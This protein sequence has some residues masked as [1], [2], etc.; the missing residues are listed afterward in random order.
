MNILLLTSK[1]PTPNPVI[2]FTPVVHYFAKEWAKQGHNVKVIHN[3]SI[4]PFF[5]YKIP[6]FL[7]KIFENK[8]GFTFPKAEM[9]NELCYYIDGVHVHKLLLFRIFPFV[10]YFN[11][12]LK[13]QTRK[14]LYINKQEGFHPDLILGHFT[15]P[16][17]PIGVALKK[18]YNCTFSMVLHTIDNDLNNYK[19]SID[20]VDVFGF[21]SEVIR[22]TFFEKG[23]KAKKKFICHSGID[24][25]EINHN[26]KN[27]NDNLKKFLFVGILIKR[28]FADVII[29]SLGS[30]KYDDFIFEIIGDGPEMQ[31]I[32]KLVFA[33]S[34]SLN[35]IFNGY[36]PRND[37][38]RKMDECECFIMISKNEV[39][40]LVYIE[41]MAKGC[42]VIAA[43]NEGMQ[44]IINDGENG[45]LCE[46][47]DQNELTSIINKINLMT[48]IQKQVISFNAIET[49]KKFTEFS[50][51]KKYLNE[52]L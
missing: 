22:D 50:V 43:K 44:G 41:A 47:G 48:I 27:F 45:F 39:F 17:L 30:L 52:V 42:I 35:I 23:F 40:G 12:S 46:A 38:M 28:K 16:Q 3:Q 29:E 10:K 37:V 5:L 15:N 32:Q 11:S 20:F 33:S 7:V 19:D 18:E 6:Q 9:N 21:R 51:S 2:G 14:I 34:I 4:F 36:L 24:E 8:F 13:K 26:S 31:N 25:S 49:A 1:Y